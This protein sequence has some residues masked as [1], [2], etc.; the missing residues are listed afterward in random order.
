MRTEYGDELI[1]LVQPTRVDYS[2][3][4][5]DTIR[6]IREGI[7]RTY[8][9]ATAKGYGGSLRIQLN[10]IKAERFAVYNGLQ[11]VKDTE[12]DK[13]LESEN[14]PVHIKVE[15]IDKTLLDLREEFQ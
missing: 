4:D 15:K 5:S 11:L 12:I 1:Y 8:Y 3:Y 6:G 13:L 14:G 10:R 2:L 9:L 7:F